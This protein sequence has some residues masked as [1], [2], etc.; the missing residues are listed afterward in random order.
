MTTM[1]TLWT[2]LKLLPVIT[3][4]ALLTGCSTYDRQWRAVVKEPVPADSP[5]GAWEGQWI[6][7]VN[8]HNGRL[9]CIIT[10]LSEG[11]YNAN[12]QAK[13]RKV[14]TF[15]YTV[16]L[17]MRRAGDSW[18]FNGEADLG[19]M[20]G[21]VYTYEGAVSSNHFFSTYDSKYDHGKFE[22]SRPEL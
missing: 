22:M 13:Y 10:P 20:A 16:P 11:K 8:G 9:R 1:K 17:E 7:D 21:G 18:K 4:G 5:A 12:Y 6:S 2:G 19:K 3:L 14:F 15:S